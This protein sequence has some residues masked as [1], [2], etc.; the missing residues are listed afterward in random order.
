MHTLTT[1]KIVTGMS[2]QEV[3]QQ[4]FDDTKKAEE[5]GNIFL[6]FY[7][8]NKLYFNDETCAL[9]DEII[10]LLKEGESMVNLLKGKKEDNWRGGCKRIQC[11][12]TTILFW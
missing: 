7:S 11:L 1:W 9:I 3:K 2:E 8:K 6:N 5:S 10:K 4:N 12:W